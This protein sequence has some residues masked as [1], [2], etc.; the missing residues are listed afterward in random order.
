MGPAA[1]ALAGGLLL[2]PH[3]RFHNHAPQ[4]L[5]RRLALHQQA[6]DELRG[7]LVCR[8]GEDRLAQSLKGVAGGGKETADCG[9]VTGMEAVVCLSQ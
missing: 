1:I 4:Q 7:E 8:A 5:A 2:G 6:A 3:L 9:P